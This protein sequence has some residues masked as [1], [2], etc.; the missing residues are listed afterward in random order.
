M[1][2]LGLVGILFGAG[3]VGYLVVNGIINK[4]KTQAEAN[5]TQSESDAVDQDARNRA[6]EA[7]AKTAETQA[8]TTEALMAVAEL[9]IKNLCERVTALEQATV[10]REATINAQNDEI[11]ELKTT[12]HT[13]QLENKKLHI[14][15]SDLRARLKDVEAKL[16]RL[17]EFG[18]K[19]DG[20]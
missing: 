12:L 20:L 15:N 9:R 14:E 2:W 16:A 10:V 11:A 5:K 7:L 6:Y 13:L 17:T 18:Y 8:R 3:S 19:E 4:H 1:D